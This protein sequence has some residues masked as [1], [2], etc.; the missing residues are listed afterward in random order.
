MEQKAIYQKAQHKNGKNVTQFARSELWS[1][2]S[3]GVWVEELFLFVRGRVFA[4]GFV[5]AVRLC[6]IR[7]RIW[8]GL[9]GS[10]RSLK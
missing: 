5:F 6:R 3:V 4:V 8:M 7:G 1:G 10:L 2:R 9:I